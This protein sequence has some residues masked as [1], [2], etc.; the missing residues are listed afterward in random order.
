M[1][2]TLPRLQFSQ[3]S[4]GN[5][6]VLPTNFPRYVNW[7]DNCVSHRFTSL[8]IMPRWH[9]LSSDPS[10]SNSLISVLE[11]LLNPKSRLSPFNI[12]GISHASSLAICW[13]F[14]TRVL[15]VDTF[16]TLNRSF[17]ISHLVSLITSL[18]FGLFFFR[19]YIS[20][21]SSL[22]RFFFLYCQCLSCLDHV[23]NHNAFVVQCFNTYSSQ[24]IVLA[25]YINSKR[26]LKAL[27]I[28]TW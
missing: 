2:H 13:I 23:T 3:K 17:I 21:C 9:M 15:I 22:L 4:W 27:W 11:R 1:V 8:G 6:K 12:S 24:D 26:R 10:T 18:W 20:S 7:F 5:S 25:V 14:E 19:R 16:R 28:L